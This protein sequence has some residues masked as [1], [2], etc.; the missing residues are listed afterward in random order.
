MALTSTTLVAAFPATDLSFRVA[1][2]AGAVVGG[3]ARIDNEY[4]KIVQIVSPIITVRERGG[5]GGSAT[6]HDANAPVTFGNAVGVDFPGPGRGEL[7]PAPTEDRDITSLGSDSAI[8][9]QVKRDTIATLTKGSVGAYTLEA[10][11]VD[12]V[13]LTLTSQSAFAHVVT[14]TG[15]ID[16]GATGGAKNTL[17]F[18]AFAGANVVLLASKGHWTVVSK[19][20]VTVA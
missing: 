19:A 5:E 13:S 10:P 14:G 3:V 20:G 4:T 8:G 11:T 12:G 16:D 2:V 17:T 9:S 18:A 1:S 6:D 7:V 15:L